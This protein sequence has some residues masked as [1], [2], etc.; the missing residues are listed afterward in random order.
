MDAIKNPNKYIAKIPE[1]MSD[2]NISKKYKKYIL[3]NLN[4]A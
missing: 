2:I 1:E 4:R 3:K